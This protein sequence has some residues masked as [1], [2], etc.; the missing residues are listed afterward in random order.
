M[1][2]ISSTLALG[3]VSEIA[4]YPLG[5][6]R[7]RRYICHYRPRQSRN[8]AGF[9]ESGRHLPETRRNDLREI[10]IGNYRMIYKLR[11]VKVVVLTVRH[12]RV[13]LPDEV[14]K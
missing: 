7:C 3:R 9:P 12:F 10:V 14:I 4:E 6:P 1:R 5:Q 11:K 8:L 13:M 2:I